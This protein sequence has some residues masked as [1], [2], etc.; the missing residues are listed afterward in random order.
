MAGVYEIDDTYVQLRAVLAVQAPRVLL[1]GSFPG[2]G[3]SK[4]QGVQGWVVKPLL[5]EILEGEAAINPSLT[6]HLP[7]IKT[8]KPHRTREAA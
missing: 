8:A 7:R 2:N 3:H 5:D 6:R 4:Y 1:Q